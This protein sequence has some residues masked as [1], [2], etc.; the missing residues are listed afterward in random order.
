MIYYIDDDDARIHA[1]IHAHAHACVRTCAREQT[2]KKNPQK[3]TSGK[4]LALRKFKSPFPLSAR[5]PPPCPC[6]RS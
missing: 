6:L 1:Y 4:D 2:G 3:K 5:T